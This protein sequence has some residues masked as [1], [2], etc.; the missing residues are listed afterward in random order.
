VDNS[1][2]EKLSPR[3]RRYGLLVTAL[4]PVIPQVLGSASNIWYNAI[5]IAPLLVTEELWH[6]FAA[7]VILYNA[8][9]GFMAVFGAGSCATTHADDAVAAGCSM[10]RRLELFNADLVRAKEAPLGIGIGI[11]SGRAIVGSIGSS[12]R[13]EFTVIG[14]TVNVAARIEELNK[15]LGTSLLLS[16]ATKDH[17]SRSISLRALPPQQVKGVDRRDLGGRQDLD[18]PPE[19]RHP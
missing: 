19:S 18:C 7:T 2:T 17:L 12:E 10:L 14:S 8:A 15:P 9:V 1:I 4:A 3:A 5:V 11:N 13:M 16:K 6:R